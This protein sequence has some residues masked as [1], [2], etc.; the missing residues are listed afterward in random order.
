M[1]DEYTSQQ[2][3]TRALELLSDQYNIDMDTFFLI[4]TKDAKKEDDGLPGTQIVVGELETRAVLTFIIH[5]IQQLSSVNGVPPYVFISRHI[6]G[7]FIDEEKQ[8]ITMALNADTFSED[9]PEISLEDERV[10]AAIPNM[11]VYDKK[12][13]DNEN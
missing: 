12:L 13:M 10:E 7:H 9:G 11:L 3:L 5:A 6:L 4:V 8:A 2:L 1:S